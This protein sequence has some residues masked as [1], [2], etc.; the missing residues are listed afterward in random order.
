MEQ[1]IR[2][3]DQGFNK[4][5]IKDFE[6]GDFRCTLTMCNTDTRTIINGGVNN[7]K[8]YGWSKTWE[9]EA[10]EDVKRLI[11]TIPNHHPCL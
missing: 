8:M 9:P 1:F 3:G 10:Y 6:C 2:V 11:N 7:D 4:R 5:Y